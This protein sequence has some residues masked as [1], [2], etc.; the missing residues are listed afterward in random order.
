MKYRDARLLGGL[1]HRCVEGGERESFARRKI[2]I[3]GVVSR[4]AVAHRGRRRLTNGV[5]RGRGLLNV[6]MQMGQGGEKCAFVGRGDAPAAV[7]DGK[8]FGDF[9]V[10]IKPPKLVD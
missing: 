2:D 1:P 5:Q 10:L 9:A 8:A 3:D 6:D 7:G 4:K